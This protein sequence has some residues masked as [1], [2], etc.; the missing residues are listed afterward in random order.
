MASREG[1]LHRPGARIGSAATGR[2]GGGFS[3]RSRVLVA[4]ALALPGLPALSQGL[5]VM[6]WSGYEDPAFFRSYSETHGLPDFAFFADD[7]EAFQKLTSGYRADVAHPCAQIVPKYRD[8][9]ILEPWDLSRLTHH[10]DL[11]PALSDAPAFRDEAGVWFIPAEWGSTAI[12][13]NTAAVPADA[14]RTLQ[15]FVDPAWAG[16]VSLPANSDDL[17]ALGLLAT[18]TADWRALTDSRIEAAAAWLRRA[19]RNVRA[20]WSD[21]AELAQLMATGEV[22]IAWA[23][24]ETPATLAAEGHPIAFQ[25]EAAEGS[26]Q[27][28]CGWVNLK[29]GPGS[30]DLAHD[31]LNAWTAPETAVHI[32]ENWGYGHGNAAAMAAMD[33]AALAALGLGPVTAPVLT[34]VPLPTAVRDRLLVEIEKIKAGF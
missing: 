18:G 30:E 8:A 27:W 21:G 26:S 29:D 3:L 33:P 13:W 19:H 28:T 16:R 9:G 34:Q 25:R 10:A 23:W 7:D 12:A 2:N 32:V 1:A 24:N 14:V 22:L 20:Y 17:W 15:V 6:D 31:F 5:T 11:D 4:A